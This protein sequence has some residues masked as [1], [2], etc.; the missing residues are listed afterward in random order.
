MQVRLETGCAGAPVNRLRESNNRL[1]WLFF[2]KITASTSCE[3][4][5]QPVDIVDLQVAFITSSNNAGHEKTISGRERITERRRVIFI[6]TL[7]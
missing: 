7:L 5:K 1:N 3:N 4:F 2:S 6:A